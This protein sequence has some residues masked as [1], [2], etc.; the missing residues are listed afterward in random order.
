M[1][2][3]DNAIVFFLPLSTRGN[4]NPLDPNKFKRFWHT[5][6]IYNGKVYETFSNLRYALGNQ[7]RIDELKELNAIFIESHIIVSKLNSELKS[8]TSCDEFVLR[9]LGLSDK[10]GD[11]KGELYPD[12]VYDLLVKK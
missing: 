6:I 5:G 1:N 2:K 4:L 12:D 9:V 8:G 7:K 3:T 11:N 10:V